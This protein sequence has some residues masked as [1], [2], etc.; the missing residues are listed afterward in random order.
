MLKLDSVLTV[1]G[2]N[3]YLIG[4]RHELHIRPG[5]LVSPLPSE[6]PPL[7]D[8]ED[9][10]YNELEGMPMHNTVILVNA[11]K[12]AAVISEGGLLADVWGVKMHVRP[13]ILG[14]PPIVDVPYV[15][16]RLQMTWLHDTG[17]DA[18][19]VVAAADPS[20]S[21]A[22]IIFSHLSAR[23]PENTIQALS[24]ELSN[25]LKS[26]GVELYI[27]AKLST[28]GGSDDVFLEGAALRESLQS[29]LWISI[30]QEFCMGQALRSPTFDPLPPAMSPSST[31]SNPRAGPA[32][33]M[34]FG[35]QQQDVLSSWV[36]N[37]ILTYRHGGDV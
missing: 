12:A 27:S 24:H 19:R 15:S 14:L 22:A 37:T 13:T 7:I 32:S 8:E 20:T 29:S 28:S 21:L 30:P 18:R 33:I 34:V 10:Q 6:L 3:L 25:E 36:Y 2:L 31:T 16:A 9:D 17:H 26:T 5:D 23:K 35:K 4:P 11:E 1:Q